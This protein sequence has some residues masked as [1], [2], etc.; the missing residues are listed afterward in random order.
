MEIVTII[1]SVSVGFVLI[2][3]GIFKLFSTDELKKFIIDLKIINSGLST[4]LSRIFPIIEISIGSLLILFNNSI[5]VNIS[6]IILTFT[7]ILVNLIALNKGEVKDCHCFGNII[8]TKMGHGGV[9]QSSL[10]VLSL[11]PNFFN[12]NIN[13]IDIANSMKTYEILAGLFISL[14][15]SFSLI[16]FRIVIERTFESE[17]LIR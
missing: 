16:V 4:I 1:F 3:S 6:A 17:K 12:H 15:W 13:L 11:L 14:I 9:I 7:F 5:L 2:L 8:K 10:L